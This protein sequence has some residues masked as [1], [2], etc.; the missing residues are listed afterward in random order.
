MGGNFVCQSDEM[1]AKWPK[2]QPI[3]HENNKNF[4]QMKTWI[5]EYNLFSWHFYVFSCHTLNCL[6]LQSVKFSGLFQ[7]KL[8]PK[9]DFLRNGFF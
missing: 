5:I 3:K 1:F 9:T 4:W 6:G 7:S 8:R 2:S